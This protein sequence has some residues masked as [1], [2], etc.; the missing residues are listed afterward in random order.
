MYIH[1]PIRN[2]K[3]WCIQS[4]F[5]FITYS[6][7]TCIPSA[8]PDECYDLFS[9]LAKKNTTFFVPIQSQQLSIGNINRLDLSPTTEF[10]FTI[11]YIPLHAVSRV[12]PYASEFTSQSHICPTLLEHHFNSSGGRAIA[13]CIGRLCDVAPTQL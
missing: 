2:S 13:G 6:D 11:C 3:Q 8:C 9:Y 1:T 12:P 4:K 10:P 5:N 7:S